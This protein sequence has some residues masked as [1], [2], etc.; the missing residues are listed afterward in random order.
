[1]IALVIVVAAVALMAAVPRQLSG[2][3]VAAPGSAQRSEAA[4][5]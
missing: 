2:N 1:M 5:R 3:A 4:A